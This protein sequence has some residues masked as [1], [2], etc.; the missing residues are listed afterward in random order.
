MKVLLEPARASSSL[1]VR[2]TPGSRTARRI[3]DSTPATHASL[4]ERLRKEG[5]VVETC[6]GAMGIQESF[7][8]FGSRR[9]APAI[10]TK[11]KQI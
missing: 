5:F 8:R 3:P 7:L 10:H 1:R 11:G 4:E 2:R 6:S 9:E